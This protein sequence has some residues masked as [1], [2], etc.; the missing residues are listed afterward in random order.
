MPRSIDKVQNVGFVI[1]CRIGEA[2]RLALY[3]DATLTLYVH[4]VQHLILEFSGIDE[5][6]F[7]DK[8]IREGAFPMINVCDNTEIADERWLNHRANVYDTAHF[9]NAESRHRKYENISEGNECHRLT[10]MRRAN[11]RI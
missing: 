6:R 10:I 4:I 7:F 2:H 8:S 3:R 11:V 1:L 5:M 9:F